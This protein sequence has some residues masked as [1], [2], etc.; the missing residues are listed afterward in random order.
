MS[1]SISSGL[2]GRGVVVTGAGRGIGREVAAMFAKCGARV[3]ALDVKPDP[4]VDV[5][6][7]LE[8]QGRHFALS[9][10]LRDIKNHER[11]LDTAFKKFGRLDVLAHVAGVLVR[12]QNI[13]EVTEEDWDLQHDI[14]LKATFFLNR[15]MGT[16][17]RAQ[18]RGGRI[19]N[20]TSQAW[21]SGGFGGSVAY[22]ATKG[23]VV[24]VTRGLARTYA[25]DRIT[26]NAVSPG[27]IDTPMMRSGL[28][29][30]QLQQQV[31][32]IPL[33]YMGPPSDV[34]GAVVFLASDHAS[35]ITGA[36]INV[37]GGWLMY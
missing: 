33:G 32:Q 7:S 5:V 25:K 22:A 6:A 26:V 1:W 20:F 31:S 36:T 10:D 15:S 12:R 37:S 4:L 9:G 19:I 11:L 35:Y 24:S 29:E 34:A 13:D 14:N 23:G 17:L 27:A 21:W 30:E 16:L 28:N 18:G 8:G 2:E 3:A